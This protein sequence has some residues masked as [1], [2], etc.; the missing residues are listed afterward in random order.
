MFFMK[1]DSYELLDDGFI[2]LYEEW[3]FVRCFEYSAIE[4]SRLFDYK[5]FPNCDK[6]TWKIYLE[7]WFPK[8][9]KWDIFSFLDNHNYNWGKT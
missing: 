4:I 8:D 6:K 3:I 5:I 9:K 2:N 1:K 7:V